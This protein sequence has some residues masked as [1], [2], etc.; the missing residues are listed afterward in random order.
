MG[1]LSS[2]LYSAFSQRRVLMVGAVEIVMPGNTVRLLDGSAQVLI[3]GHLYVGRDPSWGVLDSIK[4]LSES[5]SATAPSVTM[6][7]IPAN[8]L[9][10]STMLNPALQG[11]PVT[12]MIGALDMATGQMMG[13][14]YV[15][16]VGELDVPTVRLGLRDRRVEFKTTGWAE[17]LFNTEEGLRLSASS[18]QMFFP[19]EEGLDFVTGVETTIPWGQALG[20]SS[21]QTRSNLPQYGQTYNRT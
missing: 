15:L 2:G 19:E 14:P 13:D 10:L 16:L 18:H 9:A 8:D 11:S 6:T 21:V 20:T 4:G 12:I 17:S 3:D 5:I 1:E 7:M